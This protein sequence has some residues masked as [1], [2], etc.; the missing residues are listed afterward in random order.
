MDLPTAQKGIKMARNVNE[1]EA[2]EREQGAII[3]QDAFLDVLAAYSKKKGEIA[4]KTGD[5]SAILN[6]AEADHNLDKKAMSVIHWATRQEPTRLNAFLRHF[7]A[8]RDYAGLDQMAGEDMFE[9]KTDGARKPKA[10]PVSKS[11]KAA[12]AAPKPP[13]ATKK[14]GRPKK[15]KD[16]QPAT[17]ADAMAMALDG[18]TET[19]GRA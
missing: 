17:L 8:Y 5:C 19:A 14:P 4:K 18:A 13:A 10:E 1:T 2:D 7:D 9:G 15:N 16:P 11:Q 6:K 12:K 3:D